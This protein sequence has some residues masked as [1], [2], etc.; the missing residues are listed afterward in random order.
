MFFWLMLVHF[1]LS[2]S[3]MAYSGLFGSMLAYVG[4]VFFFLGSGDVRCFSQLS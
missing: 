1:G 3:I 2:W 4:L